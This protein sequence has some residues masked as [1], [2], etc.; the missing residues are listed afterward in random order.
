MSVGS[1]YLQTFDH[2]YCNKEV[3]NLIPGKFCTNIKNDRVAVFML[4]ECTRI[5]NTI[6]ISKLLPIN[7]LSHQIFPNCIEKIISQLKQP[8]M[9]TIL[10]FLYHYYGMSVSDIYR[11]F[12][13]ITASLRKLL[14][15]IMKNVLRKALLLK[16]Y[17]IRIPNFVI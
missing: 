15:L 3:Y 10:L 11:V 2:I 7:F 8:S 1:V 4:K 16:K 5:W 14:I 6:C 13:K 12:W 17:K 9:T